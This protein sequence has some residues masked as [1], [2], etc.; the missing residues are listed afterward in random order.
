M[1]MP[2]CTPAEPTRMPPS[3]GG[4]DSGCLGSG[5]WATRAHVPGREILAVEAVATNINR[6]RTAILC[7]GLV[8]RRSPA[9]RTVPAPD[10]LPCWRAKP[11]PGRRAGSARSRRAAALRLCQRSVPVT[12]AASGDVCQPCWLPAANYHRRVGRQW[13]CL[14][15]VLAAGGDVCQ[16][17]RVQAAVHS[18][19]SLCKLAALLPHGSKLVR[20]A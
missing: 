9:C 13:R 19:G 6:S 10:V 14:T 16:R 12:M 11:R 4:R 2:G 18:S 1:E 8:S 17:P 20:A 15:G 7:G 3:A 5:T